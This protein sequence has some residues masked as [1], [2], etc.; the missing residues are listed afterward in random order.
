MRRCYFLKA[1]WKRLND[2]SWEYETTSKRNFNLLPYSIND[3]AV[4]HYY[5][6][7][8]VN[9]KATSQVRL[10]LGNITASDLQPLST[11][12][13]AASSTPDTGSTTA[14]TSVESTG[15]PDLQTDLQQLE[16]LLEDI[17]RMLEG[18]SLSEEEIGKIEK[19]IADLKQKYAGD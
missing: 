8:T 6:I 18:G 13:T 10:L 9:P 5:P 4:S 19:A 1:N 17:S 11:D 16:K 2:A 7:V 14:A 12:E 3:S 15:S